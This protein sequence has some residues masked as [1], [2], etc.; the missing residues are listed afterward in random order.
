[1]SKTHNGVDSINLIKKFRTHSLTE[2]TSHNDFFDRSTTFGS[3]GVFY[4]GEGLGFGRGDKT[5]RV[6][7]YNVGIIRLT[8]YRKSRLGDFSQHPFAVNGIFGAP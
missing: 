5:T 3:D 6:D 7:D 4:G 2:T 8:G 1:M